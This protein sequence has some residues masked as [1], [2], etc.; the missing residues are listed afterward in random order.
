MTY[1]VFSG[2]LNPT[3]SINRLFGQSGP[4]KGPQILGPH[5]LKSNFSGS[6]HFPASLPSL[7]SLKGASVFFSA[8][9]YIIGRIAK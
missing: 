8:L 5:I 9:W 2:T 4:H 7:H 6:G 3:Q 1:N